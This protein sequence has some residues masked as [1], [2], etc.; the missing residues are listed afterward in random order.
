M[1][2]VSGGGYSRWKPAHKGLA[3]EQ[4]R[5]CRGDISTSV[6]MLVRRFPETFA[7]LSYKTLQRWVIAATDD[8]EPLPK[9]RRGPKGLPEGL[10]ALEAE[11][12][13][14]HG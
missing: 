4:V 9:K 7:N 5:L 11:G 12:V 2:Q 8:V 6:K 3:L 13:H 10:L 1:G 14:G